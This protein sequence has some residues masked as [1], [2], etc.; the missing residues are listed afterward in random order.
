MGDPVRLLQLEAVLK[1]IDQYELVANAADTGLRLQLG[2]NDVATRHPG[3]ISGVRGAGTLVAFDARNG[4]ER[5]ALVGALRGAGVDIP[6]CGDATIRCRP[7]LFFTH[8]HADQFLDILD[9][10][11]AKT[12]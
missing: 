9:S 8:R 4:K 12:A 11:L 10:T 3:R 2:L 7:G 6:V 5:D 1:C